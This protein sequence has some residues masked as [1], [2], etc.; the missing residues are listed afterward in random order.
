MT[1]SFERNGTTWTCIDDQWEV[2]LIG[3]N[4]YPGTE[5]LLATMTLARQ[6]PVGE[7]IWILTDRLNLMIASQRDK[8]SK[9]CAERLRGNSDGN[10]EANASAINHMLE[11]FQRHI[12]HASTEIES[13][14]LS[15]IVVPTNMTPPYTIWPLVPSSR[16]GM[17]VAPSG[18][19]KSTIAGLIGLSVVTGKTILP[20][21]EPRVQ[22]PVIYIGQEETKEQW[23]ARITQVCRGHEIKPP[24]GFE[25]MHLANSSLVESAEKV[26]EKAGQM[27]AALVIV[28]SAQ[29]TWGA[30]S[31]SVRG[32]ATQWFNAVDQLATPTLVIDHPNRAET[33]KPSENG[34]AAGS[35]VKRDRVGHS[36]ALKSEER[37]VAE[38]EPLRYH[39]TLKDTKRNYVARQNDIHYETIIQGYEW[40]KIVE[41]QPLTADAIIERFI[42]QKGLLPRIVAVMRG[43]DSAER[44][45]EGW[46]YADLA[47]ALDVNP[48]QLR[49]EINVG[50]WRDAPWETGYQMLFRKV[51]GTGAVGIPARFVLESRPKIVQIPWHED[52]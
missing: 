34:F 10:P 13:H 20:R 18:S 39:V 42:D 46:G 43:T 50:D 19:G 32:W 3:H 11:E 52:E 40:I 16:P 41:A 2:M 23:A 30:E 28:D 6:V 31:E 25:Y 51:E 8:F 37:V 47:E 35:S 24:S 4:V 44:E 36:W 45:R 49:K 7:P 26:A 14:D 9:L 27:K 29:A 1:L 48:R 12:H 21:L 22:G 15:D 33:G 5:R 17:L 38:G